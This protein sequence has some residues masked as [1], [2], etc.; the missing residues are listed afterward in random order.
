MV[1]LQLK[2][3]ERL[4]SSIRSAV[5]STSTRRRAQGWFQLLVCAPL[6]LLFSASRFT[7]SFKV[8]ENRPCRT[9]KNY[10]NPSIPKDKI[11]WV[12]NLK[13]ITLWKSIFSSR[14]PP[15]ISFEI[16]GRT[17]CYSSKIPLTS[18]SRPTHS[19]YLRKPSHFHQHGTPRRLLVSI[20]YW[21][22]DQWSFFL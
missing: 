21:K 18:H 11:F 9:R 15:E 19:S 17:W 4:N 13:S 14:S 16:S 8:L 1:A 12:M 7:N 22:T 10:V 5:R 2:Q 20:H 6:N 3:E